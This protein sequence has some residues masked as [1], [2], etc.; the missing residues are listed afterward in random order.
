M[1]SQ[2]V[3]G[4]ELFINNFWF[5]RRTDCHIRGGGRSRSGLR[6]LTTTKNMAIRA[7]RGE[8]LFMNSSS[9]LFGGFVTVTLRSAEA[10]KGFD[11]KEGD[12]D[13]DDRRNDCRVQPCADGI[14]TWIYHRKQR[15]NEK[16]TAPLA[17]DRG[18]SLTK[19]LGWPSVGSTFFVC[20]Y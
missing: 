7:S 5:R 17:Q 12:A 13:D 6:R 14:W 8:R 10:R 9:A 3:G 19:S 1:L 2:T 16:I 18:Y 15:Q 4:K 20:T 11:R